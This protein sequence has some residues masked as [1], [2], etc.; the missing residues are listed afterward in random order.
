M[1]SSI[2]DKVEHSNESC[3]RLCDYHRVVLHTVT[4]NDATNLVLGNNPVYQ[5]ADTHKDPGQP[6]GLEDQKSEETQ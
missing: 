4:D 2:L 5:E 1:I 6:R 3:Y